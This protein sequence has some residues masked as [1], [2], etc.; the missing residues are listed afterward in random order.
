M[1]SCLVAGL[2]LQQFATLLVTLIVGILLAIFIFYRFKDGKIH[3]LYFLFPIIIIASYFIMEY[4]S[5]MYSHPPVGNCT[6]K[7]MVYKVTETDYGY[8]LYIKDGFFDHKRMVVTCDVRY[9]PGT[10]IEIEG[11]YRP[12]EKVRN[13][14]EFDSEKFYYSQKIYLS[15]KADNIKIISRDKHPIY[16]MTDTISEKLR[17]TYNEMLDSKY[18]AV[19]EAMILGKKDDLDVKVS[20]L[21]SAA[22]IGHILAISGLHISLIGMGLYK[23]IR[24]TG[25]GFVLSM[26]I[27]GSFIILYGIMTGN[28]VSTVRAL[29]MFIIAVYANVAGKTY[30]MMSAASLAAIISL[31]DAPYL[32]YNCGFMLSYLAVCGIAY[33]YDG[34]R[35]I[36]KTDNKI[37]NSFVVS[38]CIQIT[39]LPVILYFYFQMPILSV[40]LNIIVI[41]LMTVVMI[42]GIAGVV[43]GCFLVPVGEFIAAPGVMLLKLFE[44]LCQLTTDVSW[45]IVTPGRPGAVSIVV[46]YALLILIV[47]GVR[48]YGAKKYMLLIIPALMA[49]IIRSYPDFYIVFLDVGQGDG[50]FIRNSTGTTYL[51]DC[52]SSD[53]RSLYEYTLEPFLLSNGISEI[54]YVIITHCDTDHISGIKEMLEVGKV[55]V[56]TIFLSHNDEEFMSLASDCGTSLERIYTGMEIMDGDMEVT[57][58]HPNMDYSAVDKNSYST[59]LLVEYED[60]SMLLTGDVSEKEEKKILESNM[61][62]EG[63]TLYKAAHHGSKYSNCSELLNYI[64]PEY[65]VISYGD[66]NSYGHPH[67]EVLDRLR[68]SGSDIYCTA[69]SGAVSITINKDRMWI[70]SVK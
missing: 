34:I 22:G 4:T 38:L 21:F 66:G 37:L 8:K 48:N 52:G 33:V 10:E 31:V 54:D 58:L 27:S 43:V 26:L 16:S 5:Y 23:I 28:G 57:C 50:I 53:N 3:Y 25:A 44:M 59:S 17:S 55:D 30:D 63:V 47:H 29:I 69:R 42:S 67:K 19:Y 35:K 65:T 60:F 49:V 7:G 1:V 40:F 39:T 6:I 13:P 36:I 15:V 41:P 18:A 9:A 62:P 20:D 11:E 51:I 68:E 46:Y 61:L 70:D 64:R 14:G 45:N 56:G 2:V 12:F 32:I 24:R